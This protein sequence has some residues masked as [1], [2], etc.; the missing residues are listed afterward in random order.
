MAWVL[1]AIG[2][3]LLAPQGRAG[4]DTTVFHSKGDSAV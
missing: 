4:T 3:E 2:S 1:R